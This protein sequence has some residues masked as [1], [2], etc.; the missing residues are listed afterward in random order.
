M[1]TRFY[2]NN[3]RQ[4][5]LAYLQMSILIAPGMRMTFNIPG[6][7]INPK[8]WSLKKQ[9]CL[10]SHPESG[11]INQYIDH[12]E[13]S[14]NGIR[15]SL[16][17][18]GKLTKV[19]LKREAN[20]ILNKIEDPFWEMWDQFI[21]EKVNQNVAKSRNTLDRKYRNVRD[22]LYKWNSNL[23]FDDITL[24]ACHRFASHLFQ[25]YNSNVN[26]VRRDISRLK[27]FMNS[28]KKRG[29]HDLYSYNDFTL[30]KTT[31]KAPYFTLEEIQLLHDS[32]FERASWENTRINLLLGIYSGQRYSDWDQLIPENLMDANGQLC[33][34]VTQKK[35]GFHVLVP[36]SEKLQEIVNL[37]SVQI[38]NQKTNKYAKELCEALGIDAAFIKPSTKGNKL[39][40]DV[41]KKYELVSSH[42]GRRSFIC[43]SILKGKPRELIMKVSG[44]RSDSAFRSYVQLSSSDGMDQFDDI[45]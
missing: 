13:R 4:E 27:T 5:D 9:R 25:V 24:D 37:G 17:M 21:I 6:E 3:P 33:Y 20:R 23:T 29:H 44:H 26:T 39:V 35:T 45:F 19:E 28:M 41:Y 8:F 31:P 11:S 30:K 2:I 1:Y 22:K 12:L 15:R 42:I 40:Q 16:D 7:K 38:S 18:S 10:R 14:M 36:A 34:S 43:N 32:R